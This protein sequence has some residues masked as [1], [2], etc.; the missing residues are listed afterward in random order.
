M[1]ERECLPLPYALA[2]CTSTFVCS[3]HERPLGKSLFNRGGC[4]NSAEGLPVTRA[5][6]YPCL[7]EEKYALDEG[8]ERQEYRLPLEKQ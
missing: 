3:R 7:S 5:S 6:R 2:H 4:G 1:V 8:I